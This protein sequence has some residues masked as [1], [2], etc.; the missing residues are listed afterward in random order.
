MRSQLF[1]SLKTAGRGTDFGHSNAGSPSM[2]RLLLSGESESYRFLVCAGMLASLLPCSRRRSWSPVP[3]A[4]SKDSS[5]AVASHS[6]SLPFITRRAA[7]AGLYGG[8]VAF[9]AQSAARSQG[10]TCGCSIAAEKRPHA[11]PRSIICSRRS[12]PSRD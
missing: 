10:A 12:G 4:S 11:V 2:I 1:D 6:L 3:C 7:R 5:F 9:I 8:V